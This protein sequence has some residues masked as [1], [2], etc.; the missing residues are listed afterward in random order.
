M[1]QTNVLIEIRTVNF[2]SREGRLVVR[3]RHDGSSDNIL[4][5]DLAGC[6]TEVSIM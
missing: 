5:L 1:A 2:G 3:K 6:C 4:F